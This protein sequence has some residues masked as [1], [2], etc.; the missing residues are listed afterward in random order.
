[1][2]GGYTH[3]T[4]VRSSIST[5][6][7]RALENNATNAQR[8]LG[9]VV[10]LWGRYTYLGG[11]SPDYPYLGLDEDWADWMHKGK[12][13]EMLNYAMRVIHRQRIEDQDSHIWRQRFAW[14]LGFMTHVIA[15]VVVHPVVNIKVGKYEENKKAHRTC[16]MNQDVWIY[17]EIVGLDL[18][19]SDNMKSEIKGCGRPFDLDDEIEDLWRECL[20]ETYGEQ[21]EEDQLDKWHAGFRAL[22]DFAEDARKIPVFGRHLVKGASAYPEQF[23]AEFVAKLNVPTSNAVDEDEQPVDRGNPQSFRDIFDKTLIHIEEAW[24]ILAED[25]FAEEL[26]THHRDVFGDWSLD[27]GIDNITRQ[28]RLWPDGKSLTISRGRALVCE[29]NFTIYS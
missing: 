17:K 7:N 11:V 13:N 20:H 8:S 5:A 19:Y 4:L 10:D 15:D 27:T 2:A 12:T 16:E 22:V 14:L 29:T 1:M 18:H 21:P 25:M 23:N 6:S 24:K 26:G 3:L 28:L 9:G